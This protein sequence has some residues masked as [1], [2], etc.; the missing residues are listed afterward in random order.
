MFNFYLA[1]RYA[2]VRQREILEEAQQ[3]RLIREAERLDP[4]RRRSRQ[5]LW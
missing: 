5:S 2:Q 1:H 4:A 3:E